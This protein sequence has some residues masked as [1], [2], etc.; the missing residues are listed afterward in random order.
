MQ[1]FFYLLADVF[2]ILCLGR[3]L[4]H[5][6]RAGQYPLAQF[7]KRFTERP[8]RLLRRHEP[9]AGRWDVVCVAAAFLFYYFIFIANVLIGWYQGWTWNSI[10]LGAGLVFSLLN[11]IKAA[12]YVLLIGLVIRMVA[13]IRNPYDPLVAALHKI[14]QPLLKPFA[15]M[16]VGR[17]DFSATPLVLAL[18]LLLNSV[19]PQLFGRLGLWLLQ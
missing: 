2:A 19:L 8:L 16:R 12:I 17:Y 13:S 10:W 18:W 15:F 14:Y 5:K 4:L 1:P 7:C 6:I 3:C 9:A 11:I